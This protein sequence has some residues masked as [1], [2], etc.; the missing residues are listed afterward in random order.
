MSQQIKEATIRWIFFDIGNVIMN[1]DAA[2]AYLYAELHRSMLRKGLSMTFAELLEEREAAIQKTG[3]GHWSV[4]AETYLGAEG[5]RSIRMSSA[6][7]L[8][9]N[10]LEYH[11]VLPGMASV[12][13]ELGSTYSL[14]AVANQM[15]AAESALEA[16]GLGDCF[17]FLA[18]S[19][20]IG[21]NKPDRGLF[22]WALM[23]AGCEP[24]E[25]LMIGDRID[26]DIAPAR[27]MG[28][29]TLW[30]SAPHREKGTPLGDEY[31]HQYLESQ[32]RRSTASIGP[33]SAEETPD[34]KAHSAQELVEE[35]HRLA[36]SA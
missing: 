16:S 30:F 33:V 22:S 1:D 8:R 36:A 11:N 26:N 18:L 19:E 4:L 10:Y 9:E 14:A 15:S 2:M 6:A 21:L 24:D 28:L 31:S 5:H 17:D 27:A 23:R 35:I 25:V 34:G 29:R 12:L 20:N 7:F 32:C 3:A 13:R